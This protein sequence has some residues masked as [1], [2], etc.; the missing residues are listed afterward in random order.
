MIWAWPEPTGTGWA[1][2][3]S[4][5]AFSGHRTRAGHFTPPFITH[6]FAPWELILSAFDNKEKL[7]AWRRLSITS[8]RCLTERTSDYSRTADEE[9]W[10]VPNTHRRKAGECPSVGKEVRSKMVY[11]AVA[12]ETPQIGSLHSSFGYQKR[13]VFK[14]IPS[15]PKLC[16]LQTCHGSEQLLARQQLQILKP[17]CCFQTLLRSDSVPA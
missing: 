2:S 4:T 17:L 10:Q 16:P 5:K 8:R 15:Q 1:P 3:H 6:Q 11:V 9:Q 14:K 13:L 7:W 12:A